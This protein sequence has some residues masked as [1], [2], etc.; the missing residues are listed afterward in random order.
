LRVLRDPELAKKFGEEGRKRVEQK[1][2]VEHMI[3]RTESLLL[4]LVN[5]TVHSRRHRQELI[6]G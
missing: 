5:S 2:T 1:F 6:A 4:E 3:S